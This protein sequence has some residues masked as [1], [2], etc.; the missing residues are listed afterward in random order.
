VLIP[1]IFT[2]GNTVKTTRPEIIFAPTIPGKNT[3]T[4]KK[5]DPGMEIGTQC[6]PEITTGEMRVDDLLRVGYRE[7]HIINTIMGG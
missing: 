5:Y 1:V 4:C 6:V 7:G 2:P 3:L